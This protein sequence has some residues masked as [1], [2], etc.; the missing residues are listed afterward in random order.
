[1]AIKRKYLFNE[2]WC[3]Q[4]TSLNEIQ[5]SNIEQDKKKNS[6]KEKCSLSQQ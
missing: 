1:M 5:A 4:E 6:S 2:F 3:A